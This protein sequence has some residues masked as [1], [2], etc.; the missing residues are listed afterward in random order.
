MLGALERLCN[1]RQSKTVAQKCG[2]GYSTNIINICYCLSSNARDSFERKHPQA[3][4]CEKHLT[5]PFRHMMKT[6]CCT[7]E[8]ILSWGGLH[9]K[10]EAR[11]VCKQNK[12]RGR[13]ETISSS[14]AHSSVNRQ[15]APGVILQWC[16]ELWQCWIT[17]LGWWFSIVQVMQDQSKRHAGLFTLTASFPCPITAWFPKKIQSNQ[18]NVS[19]SDCSRV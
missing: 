1:M 18:G 12:K 17:W 10:I 8:V 6:G 19:G 11:S 14:A 2:W 4:T 15:E 16:T 7:L 9:T 13:E 5:A 3:L